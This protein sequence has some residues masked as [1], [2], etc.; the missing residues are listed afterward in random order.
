MVRL[1]TET[2]ATQILTENV[3][4][5]LAVKDPNTLVISFGRR[6]RVS[7]TVKTELKNLL[8]IM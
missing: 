8:I 4:T 3:Q 1:K 2:I 7:M 6:S 5:T